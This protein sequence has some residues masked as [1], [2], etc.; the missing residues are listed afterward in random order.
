MNS[1]KRIVVAMS[2][3]VDSCTAAVYLKAQGHDVIG[4]SLKLHGGEEAEST[5][6]HGCCSLT[7]FEDAR[8]VCEK[9]KIPYYVWNY[10]K[11]FKENVI[12]YF[13]EEYQ[14]GRTPNPC[15]LCNEKIKFRLFLKQAR[16]FDADYLA[17]GHYARILHH[18]TEGYTVHR[19]VDTAKDQT[20][21]LFGLTQEELKSVLFPL[22]DFTKTQVREMASSFGLRVAHKPESQEICFV[23]GTSYADFLEQ[24][25][26]VTPQEGEIVSEQGEILGTH[27]GYYNYTIGQRKGLGISSTQPLFVQHIDPQRNQ[28]TVGAWEGL[29]KNSFYASRVNWINKEQRSVDVQIRYRHQPVRGEVTLVDEGRWKID[30]ISPQKSITP[31][32]AVVFYDGNRMLGG[33]WIEASGHSHFGV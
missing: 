20:Y 5:V 6:K 22:G 30:L 10:R 7:D 1:P 18:E 26:G 28:V 24:H 9:Y 16:T 14:R 31:G 8:R 12:K 21:F 25:G 11:E 3:G 17:T 4:I 29:L 27:S 13:V 2:G 19:A 15:V 23:R 32:Q 33:G